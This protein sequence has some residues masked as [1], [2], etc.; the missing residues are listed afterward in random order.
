MRLEE[1]V[2]WLLSIGVVVLLV[3]LDSKS[4]MT[5]FGVLL[6]VCAVVVALYAGLDLRALAR[7]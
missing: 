4:K 3:A 7:R 1:S 2:A 6:V 5:W